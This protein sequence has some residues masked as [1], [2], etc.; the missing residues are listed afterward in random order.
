MENSSTKIHPSGTVL[1]GMIG[2][3]KTRGQAAILEIPACNNQNSAAIRVSEVGL[4]PEYVYY[5]LEQEYERT[6]K[7]SSGN[8][9]PALNK[10]RVQ[11]M[12]L[13]LPP[14]E[15]QR[16]IVGEI[17]RCTS[18][19]ADIEKSIDEN[20]RRANNFRQSILKRAF[21]GKLIP[22]NPNDEPSS[23]LLER[24]RAERAIASPRRGS[25]IKRNDT[26]QMRLIQ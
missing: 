9:Q 3:G 7:L 11:S 12:P 8:N 24:I 23:M 16:E 15:E 25:R 26:Q 4:P 6:R 5:Y 22:Q 20:Q 18:V 10:K 2:E 19:I 17:D 21:A 1:L 13:P 14:L